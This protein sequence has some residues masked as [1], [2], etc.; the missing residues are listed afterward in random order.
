MENKVRC[1]GKTL[2][3]SVGQY[4]GFYF[5]QN[6][7]EWRLCLGYVA[8]DFLYQELDVIFHQL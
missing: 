8:I 5:H 6:P 3:F 1:H 4:G 7:I 2:A